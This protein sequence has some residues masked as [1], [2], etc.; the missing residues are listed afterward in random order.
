VA[1]AFY[2]QT[3]LGYVPPG[4]V[5][6]IYPLGSAQLPKNVT[7]SGGIGVAGILNASLAPGQY[8]VA[9]FSGVSEQTPQ[10]AA[11]F[12]TNPDGSLTKVTV[13]SFGSPV[14]SAAGYANQ[15]R[16]IHY[17]KGWLGDPEDTPVANAWFAGIG[18]GLGDVDTT[19]QIERTALRLGSCTGSLIDS[20]A[21]D[22]FGTNLPR[23]PGE[24][25][26]LYLLRLYVFTS[27]VRLTL[28]CIRAVVQTYVASTMNLPQGGPGLSLDS[29]IG[30]VDSISGGLDV[31]PPTQPTSGGSSATAGTNFSFDSTEGSVDSR[32]GSLD[33]AVAPNTTPTQYV[34]DNQSD[35]AAG[36]AIGL[37]DGE[38]CVNFQYPSYNNPLQQMS[39][40]DPILAYL[41]NIVKACG[42]RILYYTNKY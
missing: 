35:P 20:F 40:P 16:T 33:N 26:P 37:L 9:T 18:G 30:G 25:D 28:A 21:R 19:L 29:T 3:G 6:T 12:Q 39:S 17:P 11:T 15:L 4:V 42:I 34:F 23:L 27:R 38:V 22:L 32:I 24:S 41:V 31:I 7:A 8:F 14:Q 5:V 13:N 2:D 1:V 10:Q 36:A